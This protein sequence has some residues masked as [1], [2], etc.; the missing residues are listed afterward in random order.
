VLADS[1]GVDL[2]VLTSPEIGQIRLGLGNQIDRN[3]FGSLRMPALICSVRMNTTAWTA[4]EFRRI[5]LPIDFGSDLAFQMRFAC[6]FARR[7]HGRITVLHVFEND[8]TAGQSWE[9]TLV[10]VEARLP[11]AELKQEGIL[12]PLEIAVCSGYPARKILAYNE[13]RPH[14]LIVMGDRRRMSSIR[15]GGFNVAGTVCAE[16]RCPVLMLGDAIDTAPEL[17]EFIPQ[18]NFV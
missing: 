10:A 3:L 5:L 17:K 12:C 18:L 4:R 8:E 9:R 11:I 2:V 14:D 6:R 1:L 15:K 13:Q 16:A 7:H